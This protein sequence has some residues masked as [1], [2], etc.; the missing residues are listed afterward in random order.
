MVQDEGR[1]E[2]AH[3]KNTPG[4]QIPFHTTELKYLFQE[5]ESTWQGGQSAVEEPLIKSDTG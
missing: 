1:T 5:K 4:S 3:S 2:P